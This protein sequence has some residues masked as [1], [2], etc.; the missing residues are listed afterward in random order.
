MYKSEK[1]HILG[2]YPQSE[3]VIGRITEVNE[4]KIEVRWYDGTYK[5]K[6]K[7]SRQRI[8]GEYIPWKD[9]VQKIQILLN[10]TA[11]LEE[12]L[13]RVTYCGQTETTIIAELRYMCPSKRKPTLQVKS[14]YWDN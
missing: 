14:Y 13:L 4:E 5:R 7:P 2:H 6:W 10:F 9:H 3:P 12:F 1:R 8:N 11:A